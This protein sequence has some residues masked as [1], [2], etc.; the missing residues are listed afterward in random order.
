MPKKEPFFY[1]TGRRKTSSARVFLKSGKGLFTIKSSKKTPKKTSS[2]VSKD[3]VKNFIDLKEYFA[4]PEQ[5]QS[6]LS[7]LQVLSLEKSF[8]VFVTV[9][10]GGFTGQAEAI[11]HGLARAILKVSAEHRP[12]LKKKGFLTRDSRMVE[13]KKYGHHKA[14]KSTQFSKR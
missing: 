5:I 13:R 4:K 3:K 12:V 8:D 2:P 9:K 7:P 11:R 14:R 6:V 1:G 10:G